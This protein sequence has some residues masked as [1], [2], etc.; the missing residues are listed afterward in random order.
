MGELE[1]KKFRDTYRQQVEK[2]FEFSKKTIKL[3]SVVYPEFDFENF[4]SCKEHG[5]VEVS[6]KIITRLPKEQLGEFVDMLNHN[7]HLEGRDLP[8]EIIIRPKNATIQAKG[9]IK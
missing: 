8:V 1:E 3:N 4:C 2:A 6:M 7:W 9:E 5:K